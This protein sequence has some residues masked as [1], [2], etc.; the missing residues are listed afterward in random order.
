ENSIG[1]S[2]VS[3]ILIALP[4]VSRNHAVLTFRD[5]AW[6]ITDLGSKGGV[7]VNG[8]KIEAPQIVNY[9]DTISL[10]GVKMTLLP[11]DEEE[12]GLLQQDD[13]TAT[14]IPSGRLFNSSAAFA[15]I[16]LFQ[17]LGVI[18]V[19]LAMFPEVNL[20]VTLTF[21]V[22]IFAETLHF[23]IKHWLSRK[24]LELE[25]LCYFLCGMSL[26]I[27]SSAAPDLL[28]IQLAAILFGM[29]VYSVLEFMISDLGRTRKLK[30]LLASTAIILL[31]LNLAIGETRYGAKL[32]INLGFITFQPSEFVKIAFVIVGTAALDKL[33]TTRNMTAFIAF[34]GICIGALVLMRDFGTVVVFFGT[35]IVIAFM[36][37]GD[38]RTITLIS[39]G[40]LIGAMA[41]IA[42]M[43][44]IASRFAT[45]RNI[46]KYANTTG[47]QQTRTLIAAASGGLLGVGS[48]NG[49]LA[50]IAA[51]D[52]DLVFGILC[53]EWGLL[54][55]FIVV[56]IIVFLAVYA[57]FLTK[58]CR[59]SFYAIAACGAASIFLIQ[60]AL[61]VLGTVDILPLTGITMPFVSR[62]GS[63]MIASWGL[64]AF[65]KSADD[66]IRPDKA[67]D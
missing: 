45:W 47:F 36:R 41:V 58:N 22:F 55:A 51:A 56:L 57:V 3:D 6:Y 35:F 26:F 11:A 59:S 19:M 44:Y 17:F 9:G 33:L 49:F 34:S 53:E 29:L 46:W 60:S 23:H 13:Y 21:I 14:L 54:I 65:I 16:L 39:S 40:A 31:V 28:Y 12:S 42:F 18:Q 63:S 27:V 37:S 24:Y 61:N 7:K 64:L 4:F 1:R 43:P 38:L 67:G 20:A 48:G 50:S 10:A 66:R 25:L 15:L 32:W 8:I 62:G 30:Y 52:T 5:R 2:K